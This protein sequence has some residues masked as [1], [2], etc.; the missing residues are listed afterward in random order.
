M[1]S[2]D[3]RLQQ[4]R[5]RLGDAAAR[6]GRAPEDITLIAV[7]KGHPPEAAQEAYSAGQRHFGES[8]AQSLAQ[9]AHELADDINWHFIGPL[10]T[11]KVRIVRPHVVMLHSFDRDSL[12][13]PWLKGLGEPPPALLQVNIGLEQ[14]KSGVEP[15][16]VLPTFVRWEEMG[17][18]LRGVMAIPPIGA[19]PEDSRPY[20]VQMRSLRDRL[21][22]E[23]G[24]DLELSM[25]MTAGFEVAVEEG[26]TMIRVG[27][28][29]F[30][31]RQ[32]VEI[33]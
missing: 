11:N 33:K 2:I 14:Q 24:R 13:T 32:A 20:F 15:N 30:G 21:A 31:P 12:V 8:R 9:K 18:P 23:V 26:S 22:T 10:Q 16:D 5:G 3:L 25:G 1:T 4:V 7:S 27:T 6:V 19:G 17:I 29:I 28:A